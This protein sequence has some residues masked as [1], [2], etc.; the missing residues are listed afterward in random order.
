MIRGTPISVC[1]SLVA[2]LLSASVEGRI[3]YKEQ[4]DWDQAIRLD[5]NDAVAYFNRGQLLSAQ[6]ASERAVT[7]FNQAIRLERRWA[8]PYGGRGIAYKSM[9]QYDQAVTD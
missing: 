2:F 4:A 9:R 8:P 5:P 6:G 1:M 7:D 3:I